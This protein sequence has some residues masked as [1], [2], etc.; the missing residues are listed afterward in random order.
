MPFYLMAILVSTIVFPALMAL[1]R[2]KEIDPVYKPFVFLIWVWFLTDTVDLIIWGNVKL[3]CIV[4]NIHFLFESLLVLWQFKKWNFFNPA[5]KLFFLLITVFI[6]FYLIE[7]IS[8]FILNEYELTYFLCFYSL[9]FALFS[10]RLLTHNFHVD[11]VEKKPILI[12]CSAFVVYFTF[13]CFLIV[14]RMPLLNVTY[15]PFID[16]TYILMYFILFICNLLYAKAI[17]WMPRKQI[18]LKPY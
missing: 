13:T 6:A 1:L 18:S 3:M 9:L 12:I 14:F 2:F 15:M 16:N 10:I 11:P 8:L 17:L 7:S 4:N 5:P